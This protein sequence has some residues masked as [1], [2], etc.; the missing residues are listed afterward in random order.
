MV[1]KQLTIMGAEEPLPAPEPREVP[2]DV[3]M[4]MFA[5]PDVMAGQL[6]LPADPNRR[7]ANDR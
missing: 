5:F 1:D 7:G 2:A 6:A 4:Q 3:Q